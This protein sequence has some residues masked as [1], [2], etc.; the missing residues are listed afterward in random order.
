VLTGFN[1]AELPVGS[2]WYPYGS[3]F[4][5]RS[6]WGVFAS[7]LLVVLWALRTGTKF[8]PES[9]ASFLMASMMFF[10]FARARRFVEYFPVYALLFSAVG[11]RDL[12]AAGSITLSPRLRQAA[13]IA[14]SLL[15]AGG[16]AMNWKRAVD[17]LKTN[18]PPDRYKA[19]ALWLRNNS[20]EGD[21][22]FTT[23]WDDF[24]ELFFYN[25]KNYYILGLDVNLMYWHDK[26]LYN[27]WNNLAMGKLDT[28]SQ[29]ITREFGAKYAFSDQHHPDFRAKAAQD[30][31]MMLVYQDKE[32]LIWR[33]GS[34]AQ[35]ATLHIEAEALYPPANAST[36]QHR[37]QD[38]LNDV[39]TT[40]S[41]NHSVLFESSSDDDFIEFIIRVPEAQAYNLSA[42]LIGA[43]D[44]GIVQWQCN[45]TPCGS[46]CSAY[47]PEVSSGV[48]CPLGQVQFKAG[49][50]MLR[51]QIVGADKE[52]SGR[53]LG[54]DFF[55]LEKSLD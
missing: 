3:S 31:N 1:P 45:G 55:L 6:C 42:G 39:G 25:H 15:I 19:A 18:S 5:V 36:K 4:M 23:D 47:K 43:P 48:V 27:T 10:A 13:I 9:M 38:L 46:P 29:Y 16:I 21:I 24:P 11:F 35:E 20:A 30:P 28:P 53:K 2:E 8:S 49:Q 12:Y 40:C 26:T 37:V 50:N 17:D 14:V 51:A 54:V 7:S 41:A 52:S 44:Y 33:V 22:V 32:A 34:L